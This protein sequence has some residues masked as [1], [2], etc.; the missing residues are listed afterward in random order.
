MKPGGRQTDNYWATTS[1]DASGD[2]NNAGNWGSDSKPGTI[3]NVNSADVTIGTIG[4]H[5]NPNANT[6]PATVYTNVPVTIRSLT[7][8][9]PNKYAVSGAGGIT[10]ERDSQSLIDN[11]ATY[12]HVAAGSHEIQV[13]LGLS[14]AADAVNN[15][16]I[17]DATTR[18][19]INNSLDLNGK[20][21]VIQGAGKVNVNSNI[22]VATTGTVV[23]SGGNVGGSG[24]INGSTQWRRNGGESRWH[25][26]AGDQCGYAHGRQHRR[27]GDSPSAICWR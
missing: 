13:P 2:W 20:R 10:L 22:D 7:F 5:A 1:G 18:L 11:T 4:A 21:L 12:V 17:A 8:N 24:R 19:D 27:C 14:A 9:S 3:P 15:K 23:V 25:D 6:G 26:F 16:V